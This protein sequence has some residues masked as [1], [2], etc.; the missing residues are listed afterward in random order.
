VCN[1]N[2]PVSVKDMIRSGDATQ[3]PNHKRERKENKNTSRKIIREIATKNTKAREGKRY[4][5]G[6]TLVFFVRS[7]IRKQHS[8]P[9]LKVSFRHFLGLMDY[10]YIHN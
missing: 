3:K 10:F 7:R 6:Y 5:F 8:Y 1:R 4:Q 9:G 2:V